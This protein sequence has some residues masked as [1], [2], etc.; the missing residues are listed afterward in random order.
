LDSLAFFQNA[1]NAGRAW[2]KD[3]DA[4]ESCTPKKQYGKETDPF[5]V[6]LPLV[7]EFHLAV[8]C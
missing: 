6:A 2:E 4:G 3:N 8:E 7:V 1:R 5:H